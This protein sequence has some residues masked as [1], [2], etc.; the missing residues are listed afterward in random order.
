[1]AV[2]KYKKF[3]KWDELENF[4]G[5]SIPA[6]SVTFD[7]VMSRTFCSCGKTFAGC[8]ETCE[9]GTPVQMHFERYWMLDRDDTAKIYSRTFPTGET[10]YFLEFINFS[11]PNDKELSL[12]TSKVL[13][14]E[15]KGKKYEV[16]D[17][18]KIE[19]QHRNLVKDFLLKE[20]PTLNFYEDIKFWY[21]KAVALDY[22]IDRILKYLSIFDDVHY[23]KLHT[24]LK[25][26]QYP[27]ITLKF[28]L[29]KAKDDSLT[30]LFV[31]YCSLSIK[32]M[33]VM[34]Y[35]MYLGIGKGYDENRYISNRIYSLK[36]FETGEKKF[37]G[38]D[39]L[40]NLIIHYAF[41]H[42]L[43]GK[44]AI[45]ILE[46]L[47]SIYDNPG[48]PRFF[49]YNYKYSYSYYRDKNDP[50]FDEFFKVEYLEFFEIYLKENISLVENKVDIIYNFIEVIRKMYDNK[51]P[52]KEE[53]F[54]IKNYNWILTSKNMAETYKLPA[55]KVSLFLDVF[56]KSP[57]D[58]LELVE[59]RRK[60]T[61]KQ[62]NEIINKMSK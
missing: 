36:K 10:K 46:N 11:E 40:L 26:Y 35:N 62:L 55:D 16:C 31:D 53:N 50:Y 1:M 30:N 4:Y 6:F 33:D 8:R 3:I 58:A 14:L 51:I 61:T 5:H 44:E 49:P 34:N 37:N 25:I 19:Y 2:G 57:I 48:N 32:Y 28:L 29:E 39:S 27:Y 12:T 20:I 52:F 59:N 21:D 18:S 38:S 47:N 17:F 43:S 9:C 13:L 56:E 54:K 15:V 22:D 41:N 60:L 42:L 7:N 24:D 45:T 23:P